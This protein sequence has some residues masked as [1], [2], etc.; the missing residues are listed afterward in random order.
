MALLCQNI[1]MLSNA[2]FPKFVLYYD[3]ILSNVIYTLHS[4]H[5]MFLYAYHVINATMMDPS[6]QKHNLAHGTPH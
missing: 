4:L 1:G 5:H 3:N 6:F 2:L